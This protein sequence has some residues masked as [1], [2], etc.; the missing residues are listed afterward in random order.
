MISFRA[1]SHCFHLRAG[2]LV[3]DRGHVLLH[4]LEGDA[5]WA[6]PG[7]RVNAGE[8]G[9]G[10][11][12]REFLEE[13]GLSVQCGELQCV[14]ENF[15]D[16]ERE[17]HH[18]IGLYFAVTLPPGASINDKAATHLGIEGN[19]RLEFR[20]FPLAT[21]GELDFRPTALRNAL[22][23]GVVPTHFVQQL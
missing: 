7:G 16:H 4:R 3:V 11:I 22:A 19:R 6:L 5:F 15:F 8:Q 23:K 10:A 2:A 12:E 17:P 1:D 20:W 18:E 9:R 14:G 21:L 13:L